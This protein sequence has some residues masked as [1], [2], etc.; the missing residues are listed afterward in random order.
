MLAAGREDGQAGREA[1][2]KLCA[3][4]WYPLYAW[5]RCRGHTKQDAQD[6]AQAF[7]VHLLDQER[8]RS[9]D[10]Q[11]GK[12][13]SFLLASLKNFLANEWDKTQALNVA[14]NSLLFLWTRK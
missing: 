13:R 4:Y 8:L 11:K 9:T 14:H 5:M 1:L 12:S 7:F 2:N 10:P 3:T 6:L